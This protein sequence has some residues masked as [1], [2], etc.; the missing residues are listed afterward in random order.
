MDAFATFSPDG[1]PIFVTSIP[2]KR[3]DERPIRWTYARSGEDIAQFIAK[4]DEPGMAIYFAV[5][6]LRDDAQSRST[7]TVKE[8][9]FL[10]F[11]TDFKHH[12]ELTPDEIIRRIKEAPK[13]PLVLNFSGH[14]VHG[15]FRLH[16]PEDLSTDA[17]KLRV[18]EALKLACQHFGGDPQVCEVAR[19]M[20]VP[21]STNSKNGD[22]IPV[23]TL[24]ATSM[25]TTSTTWLTGG[26]KRS[27]ACQS[28]S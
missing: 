17:G 16:E 26:W 11:E 19:L 8:T 9:S 22:S 28:R 23:T 10:W 12:L 18:T 13:P 27:R 25:C 6:R 24:V 5:A 7:E 4:H 20:R 15:Y 1:Q 14:G 2:N 3:G 21:G